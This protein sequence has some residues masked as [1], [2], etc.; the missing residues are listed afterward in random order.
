[1]S[2]IFLKL[3]NASCELLYS[4]EGIDLFYLSLYLVMKKDN[5]VAY[6][7]RNESL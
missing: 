4:L 2:F 7:Y 5:W 1:M 3:I 6:G